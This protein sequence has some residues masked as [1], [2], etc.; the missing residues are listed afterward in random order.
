[1]D[2]NYIYNKKNVIFM[3]K[4]SVIKIPVHSMK[5]AFF[6]YFAVL[7][8]ILVFL[9]I[10]YIYVTLPN[11][12]YQGVIIYSIIFFASVVIF[13]LSFFLLYFKKNGYVSDI[14]ITVSDITVTY[15]NK[16]KISNI[17]TVPTE[18]ITSFFADFEIWENTIKGHSALHYNLNLLISTSGS[19]IPI[20]ID[21]NFCNPKS[22]M[23]KLLKYSHYIPNF[24]YKLSGEYVEEHPRIKE[25]YNRYLMYEPEMPLYKSLYKFWS[26]QSSGTKITFILII[27]VLLSVL[28]MIIFIMFPE[29]IF[30]FQK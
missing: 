5:K 27:F 12:H 26:V 21:K 10:P 15:R 16:G 3:N 29:F 4:N 18:D 28:L 1:M 6:S 9:G 20:T 30:F 7:L 24:S 23:I 2:K 22:L 13:L 11:I 17:I 8:S 14:Q 19:S 25:K